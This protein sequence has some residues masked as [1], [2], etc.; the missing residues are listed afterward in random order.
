MRKVIYAM[1]VSLDGYIAGPDGEFEGSVPD[2]TLHRYLNEQAREI[3]TSLYGRVMYEAMIAYWPTVEANP[4]APDYEVEYARLWKET[5][6]IVFSQ[7]LERV[8]W[9]SRLVRDNI[10]AEI[11]ALKAQPGKHMEV[12][13]ARLAATL[14]RLDLIDEY[15]LY[16]HPIVLGG[17]KPYFSDQPLKLR[18]VAQQVFP[19][20]IVELRME[21]NRVS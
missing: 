7:T 3:D 5:Q 20:G 1:M 12:A 19:R 2:E 4:N 13:G 10:A 14:A 17:G 16:V 9:N 18:L 21:V 6:H 8:E 11:N 15:R